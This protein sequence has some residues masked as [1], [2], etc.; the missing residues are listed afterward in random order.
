MVKLTD[1]RG[2]T[3]AKAQ[4]P[5]KCKAFIYDDHRDAPRGFALK[6]TAGGLKAFVL[7]YTI[8][9]RQRL[10]V[11]GD[12]PTWT[13]EAARAEAHDLLRGIS[14]GA[15]PLEAKRRRR[16]EP[17]IADLADEWLDRAASG[18]KSEGAI[19]GCILNGLVPAIGWT[20]V[21]DVRRRDVIE[22]VEA[23]AEKTPRAAGLL[24]LYTRRLLD[25]ATDRELIA[26]NPLAGLKPS[27]I[28]VK[29]KRDPLKATVR[30]RVLD[31]DEL[32]AFWTNAETCG[33]HRLTALALKMVL[34]T[35][36][37]PGEIAGARE[38]EI[39]GRW[40]TIPAARRGKTGDAH[41][42]Y[43]TD[44]ARAIIADAKAELDRL[45]R[46]RDDPWSGFIFEARPGRPITNAAL[47]RAVARYHAA[48]GAEAVQP[49]GRWT[50]HDLRRT[51]RTGLSAGRVRPDIAELTIGHVKRGIIAVYDQHSFDVER[52]AA[53]EAWEARLLRIVAGQDPDAD[54]GNVV[55]LEAAQ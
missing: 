43:L 10:K 20:K 52:Q 9:G 24:L 17:T 3:I 51:M 15:D 37:R 19:R 7:R 33:L 31:P 25:Y 42:V 29:G 5:E 40:W 54:R 35:G 2:G 45:S 53:L 49:W 34:V 23:K 13:L 6:V 48:L 16:A 8:D 44:T 14:K 27:S 46:R 18:L 12:W 22:I 38:D 47:C 36:Q 4:P 55:R 26:A 50:P 39:T 1:G 41:G 32:R 21:S 30:T 11:I 28:T